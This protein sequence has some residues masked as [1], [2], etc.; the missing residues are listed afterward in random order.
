MPAQTRTS[1]TVTATRRWTKCF[2]LVLLRDLHLQ[3]RRARYRLFPAFAEDSAPFTSANARRRLQASSAFFF[4]DQLAFIARGR[5]GHTLCRA[6]ELA[7]GRGYALRKPLDKFGRSPFGSEIHA[8]C[9]GHVI[10]I[11]NK[12]RRT[13]RP[14]ERRSPIRR[15]WLSDARECH[16]HLFLIPW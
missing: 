1:A 7:G 16:M 10:R 2:V 9:V 3:G 13:T 4:V 8:H 5:P 15:V 6:S 14:V 11:R 12:V